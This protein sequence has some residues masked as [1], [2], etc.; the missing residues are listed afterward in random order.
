MMNDDVARTYNNPKMYDVYVGN[1]MK[2]GASRD[3][4]SG[5]DNAS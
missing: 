5:I 2:D 4:S 3:R 1:G